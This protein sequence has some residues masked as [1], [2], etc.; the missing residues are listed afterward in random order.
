MPLMHSESLEIHD[1]MERELMRTMDDAAP[2]GVDRARQTLDYERRHR[3]IVER[4]GRYPHRND[5]LGRASTPEEIA[6]LREPGSSF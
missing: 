4:F 1:V 2:G 5:A 3:V 6:F